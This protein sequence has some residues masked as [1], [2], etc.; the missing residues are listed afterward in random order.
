M[1]RMLEQAQELA[2]DQ[3]KIEY[4]DHSRVAKKRTRAIHYTRGKENKAQLYRELINATQKTLGLYSDVADFI[5]AYQGHCSDN[6]P[7]YPNISFFFAC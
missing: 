4:H 5:P 7:C 2:G 1:V 3:V 6:S